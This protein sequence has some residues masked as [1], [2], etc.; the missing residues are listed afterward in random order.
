MGLKDPAY[1]LC[2]SVKFS[3]P[4]AAGP[5][6]EPPLPWL[7]AATCPAACG[8]PASRWAAALCHSWGLSVQNRAGG[9]GE[10]AA[11]YRVLRACRRLPS[12]HVNGSQRCCKGLAC[13]P[14]AVGKVT[15][16]RTSVTG[17]FTNKI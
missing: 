15:P 5:H 12:V 11:F 9:W 2:R 8:S 7:G 16:S 6:V 17:S 13:D 4:R 3:P 14:R 10:K 1:C